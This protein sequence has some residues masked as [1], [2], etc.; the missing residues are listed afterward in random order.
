[1]IDTFKKR[2]DN[3]KRYRRTYNELAQMSEREL[4]DLNICRSDIDR[5]AREAIK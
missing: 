1:M 2:I 5:L 3:W 4:R